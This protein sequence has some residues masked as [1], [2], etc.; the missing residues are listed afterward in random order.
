M[1]VTLFPGEATLETLEQI[2][3]SEAPVRLPF[4]GSVKMEKV[5]AS[6]SSSLPSRSTCS[7][8]Y[9]WALHF[10]LPRY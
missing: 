5:R 3:R 10:Q 6:P 2:W 4:W 8:Q 7:V 9:F 1:T